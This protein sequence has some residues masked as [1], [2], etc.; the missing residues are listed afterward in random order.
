ML[1]QE[2]VHLFGD[3][4]VGLREVLSEI[5]S[6]SIPPPFPDTT[7][8]AA[9][10]K[11]KNRIEKELINEFKKDLSNKKKKQKTKTKRKRKEKKKKKKNPFKSIKN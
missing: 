1:N 6:E 4:A 3:W 7:I 2:E 5:G 10:L 9:E 8:S 11:E